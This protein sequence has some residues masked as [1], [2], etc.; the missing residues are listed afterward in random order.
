MAE[1]EYIE[2]EEAY[3]LAKKVCEAVDSKPRVS[4]P[5]I[6][7]DLI[8]DLPAADVRPAR[9]GRWAKK[10]EIDGVLKRE[11]FVCSECGQTRMLNFHN[12]CPNCGADMRETEDEKA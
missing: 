5:R 7:L 4:L 3:S 2:R 8:D 1:K 9:H 12:F 10:V 6:I 11:Y